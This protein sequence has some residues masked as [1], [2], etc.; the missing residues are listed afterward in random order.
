MPLRCEACSAV[1]RIC[2]GLQIL[3]ICY[4]TATVY[5]AFHKKT[6]YWSSRDLKQK[7]PTIEALRIREPHSRGNYSP[8]GRFQCISKRSKMD[9]LFFVS[10]FVLAHVMIT[11]DVP[12]P[13]PPSDS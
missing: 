7:R 4:R 9:L 11:D 13:S 1:R 8:D 10:F 5:V 6:Y 3:P 2:A 12:F